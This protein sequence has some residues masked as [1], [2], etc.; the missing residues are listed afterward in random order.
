MPAQPAPKPEEKPK[1]SFF[2]MPA[3][4][5]PK[6][7]EKEKTQELKAPELGQSYNPTEPEAKIPVI[8]TVQPQPPIKRPFQQNNMVS[9]NPREIQPEPV[10]QQQV[11]QTQTPA[12]PKPAI[13]RPV[14]PTTQTPPI[15]PAP[16]SEEAQIQRLVKILSPKK[17]EY[18][19]QEVKTVMTEE[20]YND[21]IAEEVIKRLGI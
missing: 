16:A 8:K 18:S 9:E 3:W 11:Q 14:Q 15:P 7:P 5:K 1:K 6:K 10:T 19:R 12:Q 13:Q 20:G 2:Q 21:R 17:F 4:A